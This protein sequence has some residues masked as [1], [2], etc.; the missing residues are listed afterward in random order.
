MIRVQQEPFD[1]GA[2][3]SALTKGRTDIGA[4]VTFTGL[5]RDFSDRECVTKLTLEH[6]PGMTEKE[7]AR[8]EAE[9]TDRFGL[10]ASLIVHRVGE[11]SPGDV[12]V[13]VIA[14]A[15]HRGDA[16]DAARFMMDFLK[17]EAPFWKKEAGAAGD[18]SYERWVDAH[19]SDDTA[20]DKWK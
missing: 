6:Y 17:T 15:A 9:A 1:V 5:V 20:R 12:I 13:L 7:L 16:F 11:L 2:E 4:A 19:D 14:S 18:T 10:T 8:I 3:L